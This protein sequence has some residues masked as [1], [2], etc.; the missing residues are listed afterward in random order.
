VGLTKK[1]IITGLCLSTTLIGCGKSINNEKEIG[2]SSPISQESS[3]DDYD[4]TYT[5]KIDRDLVKITKYKD[6]C[7]MEMTSTSGVKG[8]IRD[9]NGDKIIGNNDKEFYYY[10]VPIGI[11][12]KYDNSGC[13][14]GNSE[15]E[16]GNVLPEAQTNELELVLNDVS[17]YMQTNSTTIYNQY[18]KDK[19]DP[20]KIRRRKIL[21]ED[22]TFNI[23]YED[24]EQSCSY[25]QTNGK[26]CKIRYN[27]DGEKIE[28]LDFDGDD[29]LSNHPEDYVKIE[30]PDYKLKYNL[31]G[32]KIEGTCPENLGD[33]S[34]K[35][36]LDIMSRIFARQ[37]RKA[38]VIERLKQTKREDCEPLYDLFEGKIVEIYNNNGGWIIG[39]DP[40]DHMSVD[41]RCGRGAVT[42]LEV[43]GDQINI[44]KN[45]LNMW[46]EKGTAPAVLLKFA[47]SI[48]NDKKYREEIY[49]AHPDARH[50][51]ISRM[52]LRNFSRR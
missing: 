18:I 2:E 5:G 40:E 33:R 49:D 47:T 11:W 10:I 16:R 15:R 8:I 46:D 28:L 35:D 51:E 13:I 3:N 42:V 38:L 27:M 37:K 4:F 31:W 7:N 14:R 30:G 22:A 44:N 6:Y 1:L 32:L 48:F 20:D 34:F 26:Q 45:Y 24:N 41:E 21:L 36:S 23:S 52:Y 25:G 12:T 39:D 29:T 43:R 9:V 50:S 17:R 19:N